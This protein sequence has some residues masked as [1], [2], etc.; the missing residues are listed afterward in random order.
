MLIQDKQNLSLRM[1][2]VKM[3]TNPFFVESLIVRNRQTSEILR[4][5]MLLALIM[6][7]HSCKQDATTSDNYLDKPVCSSVFIP[8]TYD[9]QIV[10]FYTSWREDVL[11]VDSIKWNYLTRVIYAFATPN[12]DGTISTGELQHMHKLA[13]SA[14][15][16]GVEVFVSIGGADGSENFPVIGTN[17]KLRAK[18]IREVRQ[19]LFQNCLDGV[20]IDWEYWSGS[21]S[22]TVVPAESNALVD[23]LKELKSALTP[24]GLQISVDLGGSDYWGKDYYDEVAQYAD[25]LMV[26]SYDFTG[27]WSDPGQHSSFEDAVGSGSSSESTGLAY[28]ANYRHWPKEKLLLGVPFYGKNF[29][30][31]GGEYVSYSDILSENPDAF[32]YD[33][34]GNTYYNGIPTMVRKTQYVQDNGFSGIMIW[35]ITQDSKVDSVS[36]LSS[37]HRTLYP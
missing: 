15:A 10:G 2:R 36:L 21:E 22:N 12:S 13:D 23:I 19:Y 31:G 4:L 20:D 7:V 8:K 6:V 37:I 24:F 17:T 26:M 1:K 3:R 25:H 9:K 35:E 30:I 34:I 32:K 5:G 11:P 18:F 28:Y 14:H 16:H 29:D 27:T 33:Q